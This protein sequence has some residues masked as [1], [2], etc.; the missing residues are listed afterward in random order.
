MLD[1][2]INY[3][4]QLF[5][6]SILLPDFV[7]F[8]FVKSIAKMDTVK[9]SFLFFRKNKKAKKSR[10][11]KYCLICKKI[12]H[13]ISEHYSMKDF[14]FEKSNS[15]NSIIEDKIDFNDKK[16]LTC[17]YCKNT[18]HTMPDI[19]ITFCMVQ[20]KGKYV[21]KTCTDLQ[22]AYLQILLQISNQLVTTFTNRHIVY[23]FIALFGLK[24][25]LSQFQ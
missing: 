17:N 7:K 23:A 13:D 11:D 22:S 5:S 18:D 15:D 1:D 20:E 8:D 3:L 9:Y 2:M 25:I 12:N 16:L 19:N 21:F 24:M 4:N 10:I 14:K 6:V